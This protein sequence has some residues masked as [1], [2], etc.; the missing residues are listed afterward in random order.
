MAYQSIH[1]MWVHAYGNYVANQDPSGPDDEHCERNPD[2]DERE[3]E[4][5][6]YLSTLD[7]TSMSANLFKAGWNY[8]SEA[9]S[10]IL[11]EF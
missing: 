2:E 7:L 11:I 3:K 5:D 4:K 8:C 1:P 9:M 6:A 10:D